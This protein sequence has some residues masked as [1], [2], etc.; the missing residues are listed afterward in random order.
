MLHGPA[1]KEGNTYRYE[2]TYL[3][4]LGPWHPNPS[5]SALLCVTANGTLKLFFT[6]N[7]NRFQ[8]TQL[9]LESVSSNEDLVSHASI[10]SYD[11]GA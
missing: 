11:K 6:Q 9:E 10:C 8:E 3:P 2:N 5:K 1:V 7:N 4:A